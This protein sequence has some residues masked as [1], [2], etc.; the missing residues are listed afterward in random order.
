MKRTFFGAALLVAALLT[1]WSTPASAQRRGGCWG[2]TQIW[3]EWVCTGGFPAGSFNCS[4]NG[5]TTCALSSPGCGGGGMLPIDPDGASQYVSR[6]AATGIEVAMEE[7]GIPVKRNC[8]GVVVA[9]HQSIENIAAIRART[10]T[11]EL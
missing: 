9:R 6:G 5:N 10:E 3:G 2:C 11:L 7:K 1:V 4:H 8:D